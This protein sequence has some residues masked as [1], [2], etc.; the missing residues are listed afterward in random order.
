MISLVPITVYMGISCIFLRSSVKQLLS[1]WIGLSYNKYYLL[2][3]SKS[4]LGGSLLLYNTG[5]CLTTT[6]LPEWI[7]SAYPRSF[8]KESVF[9]GEKIF[10][11]TSD[12][13]PQRN[14]S[15]LSPSGDLLFLQVEIAKKKKSS[16]VFAVS[17]YF[18]WNNIQTQRNLEQELL[19]F[20][21][22]HQEMPWEN[23]LNMWTVSL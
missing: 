15:S 16:W 19:C 22:F 7:L 4:I 21:V 11:F 5:K 10:C 2:A 8:E 17:V 3:A 9:R 1:F 23:G 20:A 12:T 13:C 6:L 18:M 14:S